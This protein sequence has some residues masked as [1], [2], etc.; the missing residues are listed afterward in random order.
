MNY[1][2]LVR[3]YVKLKEQ[4]LEMGEKKRKSWYGRYLNFRIERAHKELIKIEASV[5][6]WSRPVGNYKTGFNE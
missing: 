1:T 6:R 4:Y 3:R 5:G 2:T